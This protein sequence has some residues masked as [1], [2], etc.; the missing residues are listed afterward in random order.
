MY[1][2]I[3]YIQ[4]RYHYWM[5]NKSLA[6]INPYLKDKKKARRNWMR[7]LASSTAIETGESIRA[8]EEKINRPHAVR[9]RKLKCFNSVDIFW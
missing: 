3:F 7:S 9:K 8:L 6:K 4:I 2:L 5:S 1:V